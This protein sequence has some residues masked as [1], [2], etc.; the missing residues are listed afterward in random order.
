MVHQPVEVLVPFTWLVMRSVTYSVPA[1]PLLRPSEVASDEAPQGARVEAPDDANPS[2]AP[3]GTPSVV[4]ISTPSRVLEIRFTTT[5]CPSRRELF[6]KLTFR[7]LSPRKPRMAFSPE[8]TNRSTY[9]LST[10][11]LPVGTIRV[12][13][14]MTGKAPAKY[15]F[16]SSDGG[17]NWVR[18]GSWR[19]ET[20]P[21]N[22]SDPTHSRFGHL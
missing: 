20:S 6:T 8:S 11:G 3:T 2:V 13:V 19:V 10:C 21:T 9:W 4:A 22:R 1:A 7:I 14:S 12:A 16:T 15:V 17:R 18:H 5:Y